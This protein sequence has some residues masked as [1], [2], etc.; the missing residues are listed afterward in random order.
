M[1]S[2]E[3]MLNVI[4]SRGNDFNTTLFED[5]ISSGFSKIE[6]ATVFEIMVSE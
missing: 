3:E 1:S 2:V 5:M 4:K 6:L